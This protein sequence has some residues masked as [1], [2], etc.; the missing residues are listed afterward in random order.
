MSVQTIAALP[1][2]LEV[3]PCN[4]SLLVYGLVGILMV[5]YPED[6]AAG[7]LDGTP[8][9]GGWKGWVCAVTGD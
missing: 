9:T 1:R 2:H 5:S 6:S 8:L 3:G 4:A 7:R